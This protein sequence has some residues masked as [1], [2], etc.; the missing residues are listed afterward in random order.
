MTEK[1][2]K[3]DY[4]I[5]T[6]KEYDKE[7]EQLYKIFW[8]TIPPSKRTHKCTIENYDQAIVYKHS[9]YRYVNYIAISEEDNEEL[10]LTKGQKFILQISTSLQD[11]L[12]QAITYQRRINKDQNIQ[13]F[14]IEFARLNERRCII[15]KVKPS[16]TIHT[17]N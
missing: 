5:H 17:H 9:G 1:E 8:Y 13:K 15:G 3:K 12:K 14:Y 6:N 11:K 10:Y 2:E 4:T 7:Q 16:N